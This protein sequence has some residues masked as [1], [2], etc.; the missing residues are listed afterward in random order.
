MGLE[1]GYQRSKRILLEFCIWTYRL[2][3]GCLIFES[4][5]APPT[6]PKYVV[7]ATLLLFMGMRPRPQQATSSIE[8]QAQ[9][10]KPSTCGLI[11]N[12]KYYGFL[13]N[14]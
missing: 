12:Y 8:F 10:E 13:P 14:V 1:P 2:K 11:R 5:T 4:I 3:K 9:K 7:R 6:V